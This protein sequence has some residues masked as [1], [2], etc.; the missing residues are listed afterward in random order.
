MPG[1]G[2]AD[3]PT[4]RGVFLRARGRTRKLMLLHFPHHQAPLCEMFFLRVF[5]FNVSLE[6]IGYSFL[7]TQLLLP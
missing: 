4:G 3:E 6:N 7:L 5:I 1:R 2:I